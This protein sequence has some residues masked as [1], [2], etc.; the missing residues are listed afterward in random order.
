MRF[1]FKHLT[2]T[3]LKTYIPFSRTHRVSIPFSSTDITNSELSKALPA[4]KLRIFV[5]SHLLIRVI[6]QSRSHVTEI[7]ACRTLHA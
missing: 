3:P 1:E 5:S 4:D 2:P 6:I 7:V